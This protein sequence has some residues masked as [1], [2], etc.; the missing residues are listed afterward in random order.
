M[1]TETENTNMKSRVLDTEQKDIR[2]PWYQQEEHQSIRI[3]EFDLIFRDAGI[4]M[5]MS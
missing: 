4:C 2:P 1:R 5:L 3:S